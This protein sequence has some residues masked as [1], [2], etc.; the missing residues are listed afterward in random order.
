MK[1]FAVSDTH[2]DTEWIKKIPKETELILHAG[3]ITDLGSDYEIE[4]VISKM[5]EVGIPAIVCCGNHDIELEYNNDFLE[6]LTNKYNHVQV[7]NK[8]KYVH[9]ENDEYSVTIWVNPYVI[10]YGNWAFG[11]KEED[12]KNYLPDGSEDIILC[13][14]PPSFPSISDYDWHGKG[15]VD[16]GNKAL[17]E[18]LEKKGSWVF[19][20]HNHV[21]FATVGNI[22][23]G[24][25]FNVATQP[26]VIEL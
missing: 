21:N 3:D 13:H 4:L 9:F 8:P 19:C 1:I 12:M 18:Y 10:E 11:K 5:N 7:V 14:C 22:G 26:M 20:G 16:I 25:V 23:K 17:T 6:Y 24:I 15:K 2:G